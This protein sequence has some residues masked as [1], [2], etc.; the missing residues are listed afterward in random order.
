ME[1]IELKI[2]SHVHH[3][4]Q[5]AQ[6]IKCHIQLTTLK[7][8]QKNLLELR[9]YLCYVDYPWTKQLMELTDGI[10][11]TQQDLID[12]LVDEYKDLKSAH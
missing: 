11:Q 5:E 9:E 12:E 10:N 7:N 4:N 3:K 1:R 8:T 2:K 6:W